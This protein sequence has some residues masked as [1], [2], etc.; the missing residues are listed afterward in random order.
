MNLVFPFWQGRKTSLCLSWWMDDW[1]WLE[2]RRV[3]FSPTSLC[4]IYFFL[5]FPVLTDR[6]LVIF[7]VPW[8]KERKKLNLW[9]DR[10]AGLRV[11][12]GKMRL[13]AFSCC[14][15]C[16]SCLTLQLLPNLFGAAIKKASFS[17][18]FFHKKEIRVSGSNVVSVEMNLG[19]F[20]FFFKWDYRFP[21]RW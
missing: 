19:W 1:K 6:G 16:C 21:Y 20:F 14:C 12:K 5:V 18:S 7:R 3:P 4:S 17:S 15:S 10:Q 2:N 11:R 8:K 13:S 9:P